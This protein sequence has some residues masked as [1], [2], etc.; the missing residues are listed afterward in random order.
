[1]SGRVTIE[2]SG[3]GRAIA[4]KRAE[5]ADAVERLRAE[6]QVLEGLDHPGVVRLIEL[7][8]RDGHLAL[9]TEYVGPRSMATMGPLPVER[10]AILTVDLARTLADLHTAG[11]VHGAVRPEHVLVTG[12]RTVLCGF[13]PPDEGRTRPDDVAGIGTVLRTCLRPETD[14]EPIPDRRTW[15]APRWHGYRHRALLTLADQATA[16]E[17]GRRPSARALADAIADVVGPVRERRPLAPAARALAGNVV[18]LIVLRLRHGHRPRLTLVA[19]VL[20]G[21]GLIAVVTG[22]WTLATRPDA[23][24][25]PPAPPITRPAAA[26]TPPC[27]AIPRG[28]FAADTDGDGCDEVVRVGPGWV[29]VDGARYRV[30]QPGNDLAVGDWDCDGTATV[31]LLQRGDGAV[32]TFG[33]WN[34]EATVTA[35]PA[36]TFAGATALR[37]RAGPVCDELLVERGDGTV[38]ATFSP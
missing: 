24:A 32:W 14:E 5:D 20:A 31:A 2:V 11:V 23:S 25:A 9:L 3:P 12:D 36:G 7:G 21:V 26:P 10:A 6:A 15:R 33:S 30:G 28:A 4:V 35:E 27:A 13:T 22:G 29:E 8:Q 37:R 1:M 19:F 38:V 34:P 17:P 16:D 18:D